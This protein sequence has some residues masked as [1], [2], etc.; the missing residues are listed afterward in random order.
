MRPIVT[1]PV[2]IDLSVRHVSIPDRKD[3]VVLLAET[4]QPVLL[5]PGIAMRIDNQRIRRLAFRSCHALSNGN[6][7]PLTRCIAPLLL[8]GKVRAA[9]FAGNEAVFEL[10]TIEGQSVTLRQSLIGFTAGY[11]ALSKLQP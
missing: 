3:Q 8:D 9:L 6:E 2:R 10:R 7:A 11:R 4:M 5:V 1:E